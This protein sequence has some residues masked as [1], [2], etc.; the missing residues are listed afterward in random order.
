MTIRAV[1]EI[2]G[3]LIAALGMIYISRIV[4]P[5]YIGFS[6]TASAIMVLLGRLAD[7]G[8]T[9]YASQR[10]ARDD[11]SLDTL[12]TIIVPP[13]LVLAGIIVV[14]SF[15]LAML[16]PINDTLRYFLVVSVWI[17]F[18]EV[19]SPYWVF[20][21]LGKINVSSIIR[22]SQSVIYG[23]AILLFIHEPEDWKYLPFLT[24]LNSGMNFILSLLFFYVRRFKKVDKSVFGSCYFQKIKAYYKE[25][26]HYFKAEI[27][28]YVY[29]TSD[30]LILYYF[31]GP[32][33]VGIYEAAYKIINPFYSINNV[34]TPTMFRDLAQGF[35]HGYVEKVMAKYVFAM[36]LL[37]IPVGFYFVFFSDFIV[38]VLYGARFAE[39]AAS[40]AILGFV[41]SFG[42]TS[43]TLAQ[44]FTAWNMQREFGNSVFWGNL[45][46]IIMNFALIPYWGAVGAAFATLGAKIIVTVV[47]YYYFRRVTKY[48]IVKDFSWFFIL[49]FVSL[50]IVVITSQF[51]ENN[52]FLTVVF[53]LPYF[54]FTYVLYRK[55][56]QERM[57]EAGV[58]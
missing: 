45:L 41:I 48:P 16:L 27:S 44:P 51:T 12:L 50:V 24:V 6:A 25:G 11:D 34:I 19:C 30:R 4:G 13:K 35:K 8:L 2:S 21:A 39:S 17:I 31:A 33:V 3:L 46:N 54:I 55:V 52:Y 7:G 40:L 38:K 58:V 5:E 29:T 37:T 53:G 36:S 10:L 56:F 14:V 32:Q 43:G 42:F 26:F 22:I 9:A 28:G 57:T 1:A 23:A 18:F 20:V 49:S 47:A 15:S